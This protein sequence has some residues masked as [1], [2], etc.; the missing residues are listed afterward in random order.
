M[1]RENLFLVLAPK[2]Q[3]NEICTSYELSVQEK[4]TLL[5]KTV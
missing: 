1:V 2:Y 5:E 3:E 4:K